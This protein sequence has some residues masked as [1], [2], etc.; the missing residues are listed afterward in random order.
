MTLRAI[1]AAVALTALLAAVPGSAFAAKAPKVSLSSSAQLS[2]P[3]PYPYN[4]KADAQAEVAAAAAR[5]KAA[6]KL[7]LIDLGGN[8]CGDCRI[9]AGVMRLPEVKSF[10]DAHYEIVTVDV[11]RLDR[12]M[13]I[14]LRYG[15]GPDDLIGVPALLI[16]DETGALL[17]RREL[18]NVTDKQHRKPQ[19]MA[20]WLAKWVK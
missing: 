3:L 18:I 9:L 11:D 1:A 8:W 17:N 19:Q 2:R 7:L 15:I 10:L 16:I 13:D 20:N 4:P 5:A 6:H 14:P 12:N